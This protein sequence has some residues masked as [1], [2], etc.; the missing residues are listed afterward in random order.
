C[1]R[2]TFHGFAFGRGAYFDLW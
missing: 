1:A 2:F